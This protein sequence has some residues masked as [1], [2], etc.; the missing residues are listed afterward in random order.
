MWVSR[1]NSRRGWLRKKDTPNK[2]RRA[3]ATPLGVLGKQARD[4]NF[5]LSWMRCFEVFR[6]SHR[7][8]PNQELKIYNFR[9]VPDLRISK[10]VVFLM[11]YFFCIFSNCFIVLSPV[12]CTF[13][14]RSWDVFCR[15]QKN[16]IYNLGV[17][18]DFQKN[19]KVDFLLIYICF[20]LFR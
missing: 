5:V 15:N 14:F 1:K 4:W 9:V 18:P 20:S 6:S 11:L 10:K 8:H 19:K 16:E 7:Y 17:V 2:R 3:Q 12:R 13:G